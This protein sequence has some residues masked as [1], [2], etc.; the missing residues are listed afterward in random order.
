MAKRNKAAEIIE[1]MEVIAKKIVATEKELAVAKAKEKSSIIDAAKATAQDQYDAACRK[2]NAA[3]E[4]QAVDAIAA[5]GKEI[6]RIKKAAAAIGAVINI[7]SDESFGK[8][9]PHI[10]KGLFKCNG[11]SFEVDTKDLNKV[12]GTNG[13]ESPLG[14]LMD[15]QI[16]ELARV[17]GLN[18]EPFVREL[19]ILPIRGML[20]M[21]WYRDVEKHESEHL[22]TGQAARIEK[23]H[24]D[25]AAWRPDAPAS[26]N[27]SKP[28]KPRAAGS[29]NQMMSKTF[30]VVGSKKVS[31]PTGRAS[32][33]LEALKSI[34]KPASFN[35]VVQAAQGKLKTKQDFEKI[36]ARFLKEL[37]LLG[38]VL[39]A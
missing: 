4:N 39:E 31:V 25:L 1:K 16:A 21:V 10:V 14:H 26:D 12:I 20:Q 8:D 13:E 5:A 17:L 9:E 32:D 15:S 24:R 29:K 11:I 2:L 33:L 36:V 18:V 7:S 23:Y 37:I 28:R 30:V 38:A 34:G 22:T 6:A 27:G 19:V 35:Q 3:R